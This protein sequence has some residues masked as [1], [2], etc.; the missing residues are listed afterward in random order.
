MAKK[1]TDKRTERIFSEEDLDEFAKLMLV[2]LDTI[3]KA[4]NKKGS[5]KATFKIVDTLVESYSEYVRTEK[6]TKKKKK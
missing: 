4:V 1:T 3:V 2:N 5:F 6:L